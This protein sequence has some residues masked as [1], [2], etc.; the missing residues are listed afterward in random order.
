MESRDA[1]AARQPGALTR[2]RRQPMILGEEE[3]I[4]YAPG[5]GEMLARAS[6]KVEAWQ[7]EL[8][9]VEG[10]IAELQARRAQLRSWLEAAQKASAALVKS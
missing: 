7:R 5:I 8:E 6:E 1:D 3:R 2:L 9:E 10:K 4:M